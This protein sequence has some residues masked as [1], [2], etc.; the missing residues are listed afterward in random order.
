M[1][2]RSAH[3][4]TQP[5]VCYGGADDRLSPARIRNFLAGSVGLPHNLP[6]TEPSS[7][8]INPFVA[9]AN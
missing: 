7:H 8:V 2:A 5:G 1:R 6:G 4:R 9:V 3:A